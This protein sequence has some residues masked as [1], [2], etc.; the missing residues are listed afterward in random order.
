MPPKVVLE[1]SRRAVRYRIAETVGHADRHRHGHAIIV[2][3]LDILTFNRQRNVVAGG[4]P[5][6]TVKALDSVEMFPPE[7]E[8]VAVTRTVVATVPPLTMVCT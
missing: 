5:V 3:R 8:V 6:E 2:P 4:M 7:A 1:I